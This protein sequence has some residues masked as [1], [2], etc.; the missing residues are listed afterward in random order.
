MYY[1]LVGRDIEREVV[2]LAEA[3]QVSMLPWS[4]LAGGLLS[5]KFVPG[6]TGPAG[7]RRSSFD[8]P[9]V[10]RE[11][12]PRVLEALGAM[13]RELDASPAR[14]ALAWLLT[15]RPLGRRLR[16]ARQVAEHVLWTPRVKRSLSP[17]ATRS[18]TSP[19]YA[20]RKGPARRICNGHRRAAAPAG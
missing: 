20:R 5:G 6:Q 1:P 19:T 2:P 13:A 9:P 10:D 8:F 14:V 7:A 11:R 18:R 3:E 15:R 4:P 12:L 17:G 16:A